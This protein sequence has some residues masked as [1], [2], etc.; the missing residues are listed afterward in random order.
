MHWTL[1]RTDAGYRVRAQHTVL[2]SIES[3]PFEDVEFVAAR[4]KT[5]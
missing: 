2:D 1:V 5:W 4:M 3:A